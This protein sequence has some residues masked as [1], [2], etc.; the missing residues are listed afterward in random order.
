MVKKRIHINQH[1]IKRNAK[2]GECKPVITCKTYNTN[3]YYT[4]LSILGPCRI[5]YRPGKPLSC[6][7]KVW[8]E[9][10]A[11]VE[12]SVI[13]SSIYSGRKPP[14]DPVSNIFEEAHEFHKKYWAFKEHCEIPNNLAGDLARVADASD[15][16]ELSLE[17]INDYLNGLDSH[18]DSRNSETSSKKEQ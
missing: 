16:G 13:T 14:K 7:A 1:V 18:I 17:E 12:G 8:I 3:D 4:E 15:V 11:E 6:G 5:M 10:D 2:H 9:T